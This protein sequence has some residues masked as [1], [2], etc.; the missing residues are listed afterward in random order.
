MKI[1]LNPIFSILINDPYNSNM[2]I[3]F[4]ILYNLDTEDYLY[5]IF[6]VFERLLNIKRDKLL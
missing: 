4:K 1:L 6:P 5:H 3:I 2:K